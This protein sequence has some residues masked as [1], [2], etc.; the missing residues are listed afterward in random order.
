MI[1]WGASAG[2]GGFLNSKRVTY[3]EKRLSMRPV[4]V[5]SKNDMGD[6]KMAL[7]IFSWSFREAC[8]G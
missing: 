8:S 7:A 6:L 2:D 3:L 1:G 5:T 4:G